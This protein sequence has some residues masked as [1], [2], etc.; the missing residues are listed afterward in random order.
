VSIGI[1]SGLR[2]IERKVG[3]EQFGGNV[4][5]DQNEKINRIDGSG[6]NVRS[7]LQNGEQRWNIRRQLQHVGQ[8]QDA[9]STVYDHHY[10]KQH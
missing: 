3:P 5:K 2:L 8:Q 6:R 1:F 10:D 4:R 7:W 9:E